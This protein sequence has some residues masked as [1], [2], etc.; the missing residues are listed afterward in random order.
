[1][2]SSLPGW[3]GAWAGLCDRRPAVS[4]PSWA[5]RETE[6]RLAEHRELRAALGM[7]GVPDDTPV[8]RCLRRL[9]GVVFEAALRDVSHCWQPAD[10]QR[11]ATVAVAATGRPPGAI[12]TFFVKRVKAREPGFTWRHWVTWTIAIDVGRRLTVAQTARRGSTHD[13]ATLRPLVGAAHRRVPSGLGL[14]AAAFDSERH[15]Q[16]IRTVLQAHGMIPAKRG[17]TDWRTQGVRAQRRQ[18]V[19]RQEHG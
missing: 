4:F 5:F 13:W 6:V 2:E 7:Q 18:D 17:R 19:P 1:V 14:A 10:E 3:R 8:D 12:S 16:P 11:R 15:H 9:D